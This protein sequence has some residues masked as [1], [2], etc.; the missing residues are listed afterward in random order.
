MGKRKSETVG[1]PAVRAWAADREEYAGARFLTPREG[2]QHARGRVPNEVIAAYEAD[3]GNKVETGHKAGS[4][5]TLTATLQDRRGRK[6]SRKVEVTL[7]QAREYA[8]EAAN[9]RGRFS[10]AATEAAEAALSA[11]LQAEKA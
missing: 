5:V 1:T 7:A 8:G 11:Q 3:T 2:E 6:Y 10:R 9:A 4:T